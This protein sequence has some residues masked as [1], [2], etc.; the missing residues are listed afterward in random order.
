M[1]DDF[2]IED[3]QRQGIQVDD[4]NE[5]VPENNNQQG[6][7]AGSAPPPGTWEKP[8]FCPPHANSSFADNPGRWKNH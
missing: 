5:P 6:A 1:E 8:S 4:D 7:V 2:G 3:L